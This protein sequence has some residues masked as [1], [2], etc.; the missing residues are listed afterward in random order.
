MSALSDYYVTHDEADLESFKQECE[1]D[2]YFD[3][4]ERIE[5]DEEGAEE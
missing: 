1:R 2:F 3:D 4:W 5:F